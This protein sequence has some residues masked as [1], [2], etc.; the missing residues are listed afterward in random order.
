MGNYQSIDRG[1]RNLGAWIIAA[2]PTMQDI[3]DQRERPRIGPLDVDET[4][5]R[6]TAS[7]T[8]LRAVVVNQVDVRGA[9]LSELTFEESSLTTAIVDNGTRVSCSFPVPRRIRLQSATD[10]HPTEDIWDPDSI[11]QW[12]DAHGHATA[13]DDR[14]QVPSGQHGEML[15]LLD[16]ACR[17]PTF[18]IPEKG[19][20]THVDKFV[21]NPLW[22]AILELLRSHGHLREK[23]MGVSGRQTRFVHIKQPHRILAKDPEDD[24]VAQLYR[25][26][27]AAEDG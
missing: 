7:P 21:N 4:L 26:L 24:E 10:D 6:G 2:L 25:A 16:R 14:R 23:Q 19:G 9:D 22:P 3:A 5:L 1:A 27:A 8:T 18:W 20:S 12:L 15:H 11:V 17:S 13:M